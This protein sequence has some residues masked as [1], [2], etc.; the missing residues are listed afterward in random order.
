VYVSRRRGTAQSPISKRLPITALAAV[1]KSALPVDGGIAPAKSQ[2]SCP[3][4]EEGI[5]PKRGGPHVRD[6]QRRKA[7]P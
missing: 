6:D 2:T 1:V 3:L 4:P 7:Q 5:R